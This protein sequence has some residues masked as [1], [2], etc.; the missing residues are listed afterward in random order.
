[1]NLQGPN[2]SDGKTLQSQS[3]YKVKIR[4]LFMPYELFTD[5]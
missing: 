1:M 3:A 5:D 4:L 2:A